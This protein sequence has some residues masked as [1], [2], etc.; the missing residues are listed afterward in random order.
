MDRLETK[1]CGRCAIEKP[2]DQFG[3]RYV[4]R[5][6]RHSWCKG[7]MTEYKSAWYERN[8]ATHIAHVRAARDQT[9]DENQIL[10]WQY[11]AV[12]PC[13]ECGERDP[14]ALHFDHL[15]DKRNDVAYM[16]KPGLPGRPFLMKTANV[17]VLGATC[18][19]TKR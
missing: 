14:V 4:E 12:H 2:I 18:N 1:I 11:L 16:C 10:M 17:K 5:G 13:V 15:P 9:G 19:A 7:C 8:R 6:I 3:F